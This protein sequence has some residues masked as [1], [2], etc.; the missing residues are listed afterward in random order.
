MLKK[1][2]FVC[3]GNIC[4]SPSAEA[5]FR[6]KAQSLSWGLVFD[7]AGTVA[8]H[9]GEKSD[10]RSIDHA[11]KRG[12]LMTHLARQVGLNDFE[13]FDLILVMDQ[14][15]VANVNKVCPPHLQS[16][17]KM[18]SDYCGNKSYTHVPDPYYGSAQDFELVLDIIEDAWVGFEQAHRS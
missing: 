11:V 8:N 12:Y 3:L 2:L 18:L 1:I 17:V 14:S 13:E 7:S 6:R 9:V 10:P 5:V 4:R 15:N 16:K